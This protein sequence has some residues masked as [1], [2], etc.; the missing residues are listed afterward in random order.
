MN[1]KWWSCFLILSIIL[2]P[3]LVFGCAGKWP[4]NTQRPVTSPDKIDQEIT[5][6]F[7]DDQAMYLQGEKRLVTVEKGQEAQQLPAAVINE[8]I[9]GPV[10][11]NLY[12]TIPPETTLLG[13]EIKDETAY[14]NFSEELRT[15]H[16]GGSTGEIMTI[17]SIV[18]SLSELEGIEAVMILINGETQETLAGHLDISEPFGRFETMLQ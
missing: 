16:W 17:S 11:Q 12:P 2:F 9:S 6:Y 18:N 13:I 7:S 1:K 10:K 3:A 8:L 5:L 14:V 15:G 4:G